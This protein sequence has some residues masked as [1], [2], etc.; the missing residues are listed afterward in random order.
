M[1]LTYRGVQYSEENRGSLIPALEVERKE[2]IYRGNSPKPRISPKFPWLGYIKQLFC[3]SESRLVFDPITFWYN[4]KREF[5][6]D[7][8]RLSD[9]EKLDR[10]WD[11]TLQIERN[12]ALNPKQKLN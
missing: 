6:E 3:K 1:K 4:H 2:I 12:K 8:W 9:V 7:C 5:V 10:A 11:L